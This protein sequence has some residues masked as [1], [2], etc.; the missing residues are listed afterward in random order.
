MFVNNTC[1]IALLEAVQ[2]KLSHK[3][4]SRALGLSIYTHTQTLSKLL[5][6]YQTHGTAIFKTEFK[7]G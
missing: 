7:G 2:Q 5:Y 4:H 6:S 1:S 3:C